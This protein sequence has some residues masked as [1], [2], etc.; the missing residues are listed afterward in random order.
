MATKETHHYSLVRRYPG[1]EVGADAEPVLVLAQGR[2]TPVE[3]SIEPG[4]LEAE[5]EAEVGVI[6]GAEV[7]AVEAAQY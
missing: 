7:H 1:R 3:V 6:T 5:A 4:H 2:H